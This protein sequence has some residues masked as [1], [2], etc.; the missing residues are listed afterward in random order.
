MRELSKRILVACLVVGPLVLVPLWLGS[1]ALLAL[2]VAASVGLL[3]EFRRMA[4]QALSA[5]TY[6]ALMVLCVLWHVAVFVHYENLPQLVAG[7][8][9]IVFLC[10]LSPEQPKGFVE[11]VGTAAFL[12]IYAGVLLSCVLRV[13]DFGRFWA[14]LPVAM[15]WTAD[16]FAYWGGALTGRRKLA[17]ALSPKKTV[18]GFLWGVVGAFVVAAVAVAINPRANEL[19]ILLV[20]AAAGTAGQLGDLF[21]S[22]LKRQFGVKDSGSIFPGHGGVWDRTDSLVWV[23]AVTWLILTAGI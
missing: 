11:R 1:F 4:G 23:Y 15:V 5:Q 9:L 14:F 6:V 20:A 22:K 13:R 3:I 7:I 17:P 21:E 10:E 8:A 16:T 12:F 19:R 18:E 2:V